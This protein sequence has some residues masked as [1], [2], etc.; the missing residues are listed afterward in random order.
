MTRVR[1]GQ[2][3]VAV[4]RLPELLLL[5]GPLL[6]VTGAQPEVDQ[7][8]HHVDDAGQTEHL[9]PL[10]HLAGG[11]QTGHDDGR[12]KAGDLSHR[13]GDTEEDAGVRTGNL[14]VREIETSRDRELM[15]GH[16]ERYQ[17]N[18]SHLR[19]NVNV[20]PV[21]S[22]VLSHL[23]VARQKLNPYKS[24]SRTEEAD[25]VEDLPEGGDAAAV[26]G[27]D[28]VKALPGGGEEQHAQRGQHGE[29][30]VLCDDQF[31]NKQTG[32]MSPP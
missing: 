4:R 3:R 2:Q 7:P 24:H 13:V 19:S 30:P 20:L 22:L 29:E 17:D 15:E 1:A 28:H 11:C 23:V 6:G 9:V 21:D 5:T 27:S 14:R 25:A 8:P 31:T 16:A 18:V 12:E 26:P 10:P 32:L